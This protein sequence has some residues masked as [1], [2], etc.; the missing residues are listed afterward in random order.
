MREVVTNVFK[1]LNKLIT[2]NFSK[3]LIISFSDIN[4]LYF[5]SKK[6]WQPQLKRAM[7]DLTVLVFLPI[8]GAPKGNEK[9]SLTI[10]P[11]FAELNV[12]SLVQACYII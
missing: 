11:I 12:S 4:I 8:Y 2:V 6:C 3:I 10:Y 1:T 5:S 7:N 9:L